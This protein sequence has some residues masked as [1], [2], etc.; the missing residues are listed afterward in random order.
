MAQTQSR[1]G[2]VPHTIFA[3]EGL[4][5]TEDFELGVYVF[6]DARIE[7]VEFDFS[8]IPLP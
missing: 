4:Q 5:F 8:D 7:K 2:D 6:P 3:L 1:G